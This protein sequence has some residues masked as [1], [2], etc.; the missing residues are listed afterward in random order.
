MC[1]AAVLS[2]LSPR[3]SLSRTLAS[4]CHVR[5]PPSALV[6]G[7]LPSCRRASALSCT[8][9]CPLIKYGLL[10]SQVLRMSPLRRVASRNGGQMQISAAA[11]ASLSASPSPPRR[12]RGVAVASR[13]PPPPLSRLL[14]ASPPR[15]GGAEWWPPLGCRLRLSLGFWRPSQPRFHSSVVYLPTAHRARGP[16][17]CSPHFPPS[18]EGAGL[19]SRQLCDLA[20]T[21][22]VRNASHRSQMNCDKGR[23]PRNDQRNML[24]ES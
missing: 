13:L 7:P 9:L 15:D 17:Y 10:P 12:R 24:T 6:Y 23:H 18:R 5:A 14:S 19:R 1:H 8:G 2:R 20:T 4:A 11:S 16:T 21:R 22:C 3:S